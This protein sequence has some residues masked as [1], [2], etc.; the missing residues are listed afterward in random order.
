M[1][2]AKIFILLLPFIGLCCWG[3][4]YLN[5]V[6]NAS[7]VVL[8][9]TGYDP[10]NLLSGHYIEFQIDWSKANCRQ[11]NWNGICRRSEFSRVNRFYVP[12]NRAREL[13]RLINSNRSHAQ[14]VFAYQ[15][16]K[17]PIAKELL[18]NG[19]PWYQARQSNQRSHM[20]RQ[21]A[22]EMEKILSLAIGVC[23]DAEVTGN[24][25]ADLSNYVNFN[26]ADY[27]CISNSAD[28]RTYG[29]SIAHINLKEE[30]QDVADMI[31][32]RMPERIIGG[33]CSVGDKCAV[34]FVIR[35]ADPIQSV[36]PSP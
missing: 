6:Q 14:I 15:P 9:I 1:N 2:K 26:A 8:P 11:A 16:G 36:L 20:R 19:R 23:I 4:Y 35:H 24:Q 27:E 10:R 33:T 17:R 29:D 3:M 18:M 30:C 22:K 7:E 21:A 5:F 13:E 25:Y 12:E 34:E 32:K 31:Q 28:I